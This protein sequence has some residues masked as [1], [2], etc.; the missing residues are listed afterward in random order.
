MWICHGFS[1]WGRHGFRDAC[2]FD[3]ASVHGVAMALEMLVDLPRLR[4]MDRHGFRDA[5]GFD[6]DSVH[7]ITMALEMRVD[8]PRLQYMGSAWL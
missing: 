4:C 5:C 3:M 1:A 8:L 2:E 7:G 6:T